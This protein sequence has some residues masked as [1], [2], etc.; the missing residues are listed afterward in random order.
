MA[1]VQDY[2]LLLTR[3]ENMMCASTWMRLKKVSTP[4][5]GCCLL[6]FSGVCTTA[7]WAIQRK[8][9]Q[10]GQPLGKGEFGG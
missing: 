10:L 6:V 3:R 8:E 5:C 9:I 2:V 4:E 1:C 7:G